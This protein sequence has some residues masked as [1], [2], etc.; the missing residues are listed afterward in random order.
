[1][2]MFSGIFEWFSL[3]LV[4]LAIIVLIVQIF[5]ERTK[6]MAMLRLHGTEYLKIWLTVL[7]EMMFVS[8]L[9]IAVSFVL[10]QPLLVLVSA[11][12]GIEAIFIADFMCYLWTFLIVFLITVVV[13]TASIPRVYKLSIIDTLK[14][15]E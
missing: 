7:F 6:E 12:A 13:A 4:L 11:I 8:I 3:V 2:R 10:C 14:T 15:P 5:K 1:M 9:G